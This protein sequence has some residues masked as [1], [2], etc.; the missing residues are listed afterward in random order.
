MPS[1]LPQNKV[2]SLY[3]LAV[4]KVGQHV[5]CATIESANPPFDEA[6]LKK[7]KVVLPIAITLYKSVIII[8]MFQLSAIPDNLYLWILVFGCY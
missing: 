7:V 5:G 1:T 4:I 2:S 3:D 8:M 6:T